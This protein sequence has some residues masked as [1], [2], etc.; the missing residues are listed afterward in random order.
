L[1][2]LP[3][4]QRRTVE[5]AYFGGMTQQEIAETTG[6]PLGTVKSRVRLGLS[7]LRKSLSPAYIEP[8]VIGTAS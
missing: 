3:H 4:A 2:E 6:A 5:L 8:K 7:G 1:A